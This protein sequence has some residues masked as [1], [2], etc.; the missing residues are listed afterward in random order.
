MAMPGRVRLWP[1]AQ[2]VGD[3]GPQAAGRPLPPG[4]GC[5]GAQPRAVAQQ[6]KDGRPARPCAG[7]VL[8]QRIVQVDQALVPQPQ[9][10]NGRERLGDRTDPVLRIGVG[11]MPL[12]ART[13]P[14]PGRTPLSPH[15]GHQGRRAAVPLRDGDAVQQGAS[16]TGKQVFVDG[17]HG[18][19]PTRRATA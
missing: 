13:R 8:L 3:L 5:F 14:T 16:G 9:N 6:L 4:G 1:V 17:S 2:H 10:Q 18:P 15:R 7:E 12:D 19:T 11:S